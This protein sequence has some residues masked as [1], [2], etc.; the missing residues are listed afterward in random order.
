MSKVLFRKPSPDIEENGFNPSFSVPMSNPLT[1]KAANLFNQNIG[2]E[3]IAK[4]T[5]SPKKGLKHTSIT[6][7]NQ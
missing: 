3:D 6:N 1:N 5:A 4:Y 2:N 7:Q